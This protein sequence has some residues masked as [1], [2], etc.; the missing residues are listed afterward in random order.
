MVNENGTQNEL[1]AI[2]WGNRWGNPLRL[3]FTVA[4]QYTNAIFS[5]SRWW[6][7]REGY[8]YNSRTHTLRKLVGLP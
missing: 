2:R 7:N 6:G 4:R 5:K 1:D 8:P 3:P